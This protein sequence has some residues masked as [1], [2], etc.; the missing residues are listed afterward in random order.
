MSKNVPSQYID[1]D[2]ENARLAGMYDEQ[3]A[4]RRGRAADRIKSV[5]AVHEGM[6]DTYKKRAEAIRRATDDYTSQKLALEN[7]LKQNDILRARLGREAISDAERQSLMSLIK[8]SAGVDARALAK[9]AKTYKP[10]L[11]SLTAEYLQDDDRFG[12]FGEPEVLEKVAFSEVA[13]RRH[14]ADNREESQEK[15]K[16]LAELE[17]VCKPIEDNVDK[18]Y[19]RVT[20]EM[21]DLQSKM[22]E[23]VKDAVNTLEGRSY[24]QAIEEVKSIYKR[25]KLLKDNIE[26]CENPE[27]VGVPFFKKPQLIDEKGKKYTTTVDLLP[28]RLKEFQEQLKQ[29]KEDFGVRFDS[30]VKSVVYFTKNQSL[31]EFSIN[32]SN[33]DAYWSVSRLQPLRDKDGRIM[34]RF[35]NLFNDKKSE[36][37]NRLNEIQEMRDANIRALNADF[38]KQMRSAVYGLVTSVG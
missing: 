27:M 34:D 19:E 17:A 3:K 4:A 23:H 2:A 26:L 32:E 10:Q 7:K 18:L 15:A 21:A 8:K 29:R 6:T 14:R 28:E 11:D 37:N 9:V 38:E 33:S 25:V 36:L 35:L 24:E 5:Q 13:L 30:L 16:Y 20:R 12:D 1:L 22:P 31:H